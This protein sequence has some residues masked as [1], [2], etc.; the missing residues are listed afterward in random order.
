[1]RDPWERLKTVVEAMAKALSIPDKIFRDSLIGN[2]E[3]LLDLMPDLNVTG[4]PTLEAMCSKIRKALTQGFDAKDG[5]DPAYKAKQDTDSTA[6][7]SS[8][9]KTLRESKALEA[10]DILAEINS[11]M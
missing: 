4:D 11:V 5:R 10:R 7:R 9:A 1:M 3:N 8:D 6:N 2:V